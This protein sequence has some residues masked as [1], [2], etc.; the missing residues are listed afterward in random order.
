MKEICLTASKSK[1]KTQSSNEV[2]PL[3]PSWSAISTYVVEQ[4]TIEEKS[5]KLTFTINTVHVD[6]ISPVDISTGNSISNEPAEKRIRVC[7][8]EHT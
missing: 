7:S 6:S 4:N 3:T 8:S 5:Q 1:M 2:S